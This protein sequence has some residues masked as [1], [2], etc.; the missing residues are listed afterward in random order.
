MAGFTYL[1]GRRDDPPIAVGMGIADL[2]AGLHIVYGVLAAVVH[3]ERTGK[4]QRV[5]VNLLDSLLALQSQELTAHLNGIPVPERSAAG[6]PAPYVGP[7]F[8]IYKTADSYI[9]IAM[10]PMNKL[11]RLIGLSGYEECEASNI[12]ERRDEIRRDLEPAFLARTTAEWLEC[13]LAEDI[14]CAPVNDYA[15]VESDPQVR[16]NEMIVDYHHPTV[17]R[18]RGVGQPVKFSET[19]GAIHRPAPLKG[20]HTRQVLAELGF[21]VAE[22]DRLLVEGVVA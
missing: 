3:R 5:D 8:G 16:E 22:V 21:T 1:N 15:A 6:V 7:P 10:S 11:T 2:V 13:L 4:G 14:W 17:G 12:T 9:A 19:P 18:V 20:E